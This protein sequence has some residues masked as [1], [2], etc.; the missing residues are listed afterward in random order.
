MSFPADDPEP[1][2]DNYEPYYGPSEDHKRRVREAMAMGWKEKTIIAILVGAIVA[3][4][5]YSF[6]DE[7]REI[8]EHGTRNHPIS[9]SQDSG[10]EKSV[11]E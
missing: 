3:Y 7:Y 1:G 4:C 10:L 8:R 9:R 5:V 6:A 2:D 11:D